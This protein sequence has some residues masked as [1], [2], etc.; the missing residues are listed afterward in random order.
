MNLPIFDYH[1]DYH[2]DSALLLFKHRNKGSQAIAQ[3]LTGVHRHRDRVK[4][5]HKK[6]GTSD[7]L[8]TLPP[9]TLDCICSMSGT[10]V[11]VFCCWREEG[12]LFP[13][14]LSIYASVPF[15]FSV[16]LRIH[17]MRV[18]FVLLVFF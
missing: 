3:S 2:F 18:F 5:K 14:T 15:L 1:F 12:Q 17:S 13:L 16:P 6:R 9:L 7:Q 4:H 8:F 11:L 10:N